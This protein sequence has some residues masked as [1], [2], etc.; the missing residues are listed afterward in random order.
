MAAQQRSLVFCVWSVYICTCT[1]SNIQAVSLHAQRTPAAQYVRGDHAS[2]TTG[3]AADTVPH[4][5][6]RTTVSS[7]AL[8]NTHPPS[9]FG[10]H[11]PSPTTSRNHHRAQIIHVPNLW[12]CECSLASHP[13]LGSEIFDSPHPRSRPLKIYVSLAQKHIRFLLHSLQVMQ[14]RRRDRPHTLCS[15]AQPS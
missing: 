2:Q 9:L 6:E 11:L 14:L 7:R 1:P 10:P 12:S 13:R 3:H 8:P 5:A 4:P 15:P